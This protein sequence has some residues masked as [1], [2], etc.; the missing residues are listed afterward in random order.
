ME[1]IYS[2]EALIVINKPIG[3]LSVPGRGIEKQDCAIARVREL[4]ADALVVHRLDMATSGLL[5]F[6]RGKENQRLLSMAFAKRLVDKTYIAHV[7]GF[8]K[9]NNGTIELPLAAD[10]PNRPKQKV[11]YEHGKPS[12]TQWQ[13]LDCLPDHTMSVL[14]L[15]PLT[16]R[17]HQLRVHLS[18]IG[19]PIIGDRLYAPENLI[20]PYPRMMLHANGLKF[21]HPVTNE[22]VEFDCVADFG[23]NI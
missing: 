23:L 15:T 6:A 22:I 18:A 20:A 4:Y 8:P 17:S 2:D 16:G 3:M 7:K 13:L 1:F 5:L 14:K 10:W 21:V 11:C 9:E 19:H 12:I